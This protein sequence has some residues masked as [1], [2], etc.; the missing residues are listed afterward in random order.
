MLT[1][2]PGIGHKTALRIAFFLL[3]QRNIASELVS[4]VTTAHEKLHECP[5][6]LNLTEN[7]LCAIC[8][9]R[10]RDHSTICVVEDPAD[11]LTLEQTHQYHGVYHILGGL[12]SP[13]DNIGPKELHITSLLQRVAAGG[14]TEVILAT[15]PT[16]EGE[17]TASYVYRQLRAYPIRITR[18]ARGLPT[19]AD[20]GIADI[21][22]LSHAFEGRSDITTT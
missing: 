12:L 5:I 2:L 21:D 11:V 8:A 15:N 13:I 10:N 1:E 20:I 3:K 19:G 14:I 7:S 16:V 4:A 9:D 17:A 22:T 18:L 6:C